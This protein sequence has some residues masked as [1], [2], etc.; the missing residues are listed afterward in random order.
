[1]NKESVIK[2]VII[3]VI[4][5]FLALIGY[6]L[7]NDDNNDTYVLSGGVVQSQEKIIVTVTGEV[8]KAGKYSVSLGSTLHE[9]IY[10]AGGI[11]ENADLSS[12]N[13]DTHI[14]SDCT[15]EIPKAIYV[16]ESLQIDES[17]LCNINTASLEE[18]S[19]LPE[20]GDVTARDI[21]NYREVNGPFKSIEEICNVSGIGNKRYE[22]IKDKITVGGI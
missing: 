3:T 5:A 4:F 19:A 7:S 20:I 9:I 22:A 6:R 17:S 14:V 13:L 1:M 12:L 18:L 15:I 11:T 8:K 10:H 2:I 16:P 21:I